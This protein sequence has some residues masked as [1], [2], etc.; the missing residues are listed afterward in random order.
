VLLKVNKWSVMMGYKGKD[1]RLVKTP[2]GLR[3]RETADVHRV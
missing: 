1:P 3:Y 2:G